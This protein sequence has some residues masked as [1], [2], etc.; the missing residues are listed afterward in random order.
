MNY[1]FNLIYNIFTVL[2]PLI[3]TPYVARVLQADGV[4]LYSYT[5]SIAT[6]FVALA[7]FG[8]STYGQRQIAYCRN[9]LRERSRVF[10]NVFLLRF[11]NVAISLAI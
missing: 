5:Y 1:V 9:D 3:T 8:T 7:Q 6:A 11:M 10:W 4:G 2:T